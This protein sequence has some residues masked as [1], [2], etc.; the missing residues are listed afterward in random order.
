MKKINVLILYLIELISMIIVLLL[1]FVGKMDGDLGLI[2][3]DGIAFLP[4]SLYVIF[5]IA[6]ILESIKNKKIPIIRIITLLIGILSSIMMYADSN[7][8]SMLNATLFIFSIVLF[9]MV[10]VRMLKKLPNNIDEEKE[11]EKTLPDGIYSNKQMIMQS[12][13]IMIVFVLVSIVVILN[14]FNLIP[15]QPWILYL[16]LFVV[17]FIFLF[18]FMIIFN[19]LNK[20]FKYINIE[21]SYSKFKK[22]LFEIKNNKL[23][24]NSI[25]YLNIAFSNYTFV[26]DVDLACK[27][28]EECQVPKNKAQKRIYDV[29]NVNYYICKNNYDAAKQI[30][31]NLKEK[32]I[33]HSI[34]TNLE[35]YL[36]VMLTDEEI[37]NI[38]ELINYS[39]RT[40][41]LNIG[42]Y[43]TLMIYY[44][45]R[46]NQNK[47]IEY[48]NKI[49]SANTDF[50]YYNNEA[51]K[52]INNIEIDEIKNN[53][54]NNE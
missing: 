8:I 35:N 17:S 20:V 26:Y 54:G 41:F 16:I 6:L 32:K 37:V 28:F 30:I 21:L 24:P 12:I 43:F 25:N 14:I 18:I 9:T 48:A 11:K 38:E 40:N 29:V 31:D 47:A 44:N 49:I 22:G 36:K 50:K 46:G 1:S 45:T 19:P 4:I 51:N 23:H 34:V 27:L 7:R 10:I 13:G 53:I 3:A 42:N 15:F 5:T 33:N 2:L 52:V 39:K